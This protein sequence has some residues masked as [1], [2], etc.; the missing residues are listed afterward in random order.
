MVGWIH[1][2][3]IVNT[4]EPQKVGAGISE[5]ICGFLTVQGGGQSTPPLLAL[6]KGQLHLFFEV[7]PGLKKMIYSNS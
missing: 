7:S 5:F 2:C 4:E 1:G 6:F 3:G